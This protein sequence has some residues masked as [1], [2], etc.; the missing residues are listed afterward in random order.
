MNMIDFVFNDK[1]LSDYG[2]I[3]VSITTS[4]EQNA[5]LGSNI[6][7][8]TL[9]NNAT[10][11][12][13]IIKTDYNEPISVTFD[14][15]KNP[16]V[17]SDKMN[18]DDTEI[19]FMMRWLNTKGYKIFKPI[20]DDDSYPSIY[21]KGS[22]NVTAIRVGGDVVGLTL[23]FTANSPFGYDD[24]QTLK[25]NINNSYDTFTFYDNSDEYGYLYPDKFII[26]CKSKGDFIMTNNFDT[27]FVRINNCISGEI[28]VLNCINKVIQSNKTHSTLYNDFNYKY[29]RF[30]VNENTNQNVFAVSLPCEIQVVYSLVRK[31]GIII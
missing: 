21:F 3:V 28:I 30:V 25:F 27:S 1:R 12:N 29:P 31:A 14:I 18:I 7:F 17:S 15:C 5:S 11:V 4:Y 10:F 2:Y 19:S 24:E 9:K 20:Y 23:T 26:T 22:F 16:C 6:T 8:E 13:R